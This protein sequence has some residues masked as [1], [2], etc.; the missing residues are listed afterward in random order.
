[1]SIRGE[2]P[3]LKFT[4]AAGHSLQ[5]T[6]LFIEGVQVSVLPHTTKDLRGCFYHFCRVSG[7]KLRKD[8]KLFL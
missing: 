8:E 5:H 1:M 7:K 3:H 6:Y 2:Q 4:N